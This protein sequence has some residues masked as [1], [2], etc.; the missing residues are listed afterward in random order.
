MLFFTP[1]TDA[2]KNVF[3]FLDGK[4]KLS[5]SFTAAE[6]SHLEDVKQVMKY[7]D[8]MF[9]IL[10][11]GFTLTIIFYRKKKDFLLNLLHLG[12]KVTFAVMILLGALSLISFDALFAIFHRIFFPQGNWLF[13]ADSKIIQ[14]FPLDFF[15]SLSRNIFLLT[16]FLG[17]LFILLGYY[18]KDV[19]SD[20][21]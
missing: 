12:G 3:L 16:L 14:T 20:R 9:Y 7:A 18:F 11:L 10:L 15:I 2:Q 5:T 4:Q 19:D 21:N 6:V 1:L 17:I 13:A 8:Y